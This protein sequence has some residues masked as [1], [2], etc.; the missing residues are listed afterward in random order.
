MR[1]FDDAAQFRGNKVPNLLDGF[2]CMKFQRI[3]FNDRDIVPSKKAC[4]RVSVIHMPYAGSSLDRAG[5]IR[6]I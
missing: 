5:I 1:S 3:E 4:F 2:I 6:R